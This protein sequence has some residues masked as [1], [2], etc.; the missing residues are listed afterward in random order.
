MTAGAIVPATAAEAQS[1]RYYRDYD[2]RYYDNRDYRDY[3]RYN[4]YRARQKCRDGDGGT[5]VGAI[6]GGLIVSQLLTLFTTPVIYL[7]F[8]RAARRWGGQAPA[9]P[10]EVGA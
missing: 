8:D 10:K 4:N 3:R 7:A 5:I 6:A 1:R 2:R 9:K